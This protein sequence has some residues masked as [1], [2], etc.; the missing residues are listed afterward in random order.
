MQYKY[1][2]DVITFDTTYKTNLYDMPFG[3]FVGVNNLI[4]SIILGGVL[5]RD[6]RVESVEWIFSKFVCM[7]GG[8]APQT[9]LTGNFPINFHVFACYFVGVIYLVLT[10]LSHNC[11]PEQGNGGGFEKCDA[12][13]NSPLV[14]MACSEESKRMSWA[15]VHQKEHILS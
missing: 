4:Q 2:D 7:M 3:L 12:Q 15:Y 1:F 10:H 6:E 5:V 14:Q 11:R 9:I 13:H 8:V